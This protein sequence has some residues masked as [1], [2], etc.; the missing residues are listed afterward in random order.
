LAEGS[1]EEKAKEYG[2]LFRAKDNSMDV[3]APETFDIPGGIDPVDQLP[4]R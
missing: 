4:P 2:L 3:L 1:Y